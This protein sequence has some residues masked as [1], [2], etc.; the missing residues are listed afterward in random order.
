[1]MMPEISNL[2]ADT[3]ACEQLIHLNNAG[4]SLAPLAVQNAVKDYLDFEAATGGYE[5][6]DVKSVAIAD[7]YHALA[8][9][10]HTL[11]ANIAWAASATD[12]YARALSFVDWK[13]GDILLTTN[14]DYVSNQLAFFSLRDRFGVQIIRARDLPQGGVNPADMAR[15][16]EQFRPK[17]VA[18][19]HIPTNSGL[20]QPV[21]AIGK[22]CRSF[23]TLYLVDACQSAG[24]WVLDVTAIGCDFLTGTMRK[25][26]RGPRGAGFMYVSDRVLHSPQ[27]MLFPDMTGANWTGPDSWDNAPTAARFEYF[28]HSPAVKI[29]SAVAVRYLLSVGQAWVQERIQLLAAGLREQ[30]REIPGARILDEGEVLSGIVTVSHPI[31]HPVK[32]RDWLREQ[33]VNTSVTAIGMARI[34]FGRKGVEMAL[35]LSPHYYNTREEL[36]VAVE[37]IK[38]FIVNA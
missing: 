14:N 32:L 4:A 18:V 21:E 6:A 1:M 11:P 33:K 30:L 9:L 12:G 29:G 13:P 16:I 3:P 23:N 20:V 31:F 35:R 7:Y 19:T 26:M 28:E 34:D 5:A 36:T 15:L 25:F 24:Q 8:E 27:T 17:M 37:L 22:V 2:R 38:K 10:L